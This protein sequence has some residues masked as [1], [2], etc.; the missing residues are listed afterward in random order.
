MRPMQS[1]NSIVLYCAI[2]NTQR[3]QP[4]QAAAPPY[5]FYS[6]NFWKWILQSRWL[7]LF[8]LLRANKRENGDMMVLGKRCRFT[9]FAQLATT[10]FAP[11]TN[12]CVHTK[13]INWGQRIAQIT[14]TRLWRCIPC[15]PRNAFACNGK[16]RYSTKEMVFARRTFHKKS[17]DA[18]KQTRKSDSPHKT[19]RER[20][21]Q[22]P[23]ASSQVKKQAIFF[24]KA[25]AVTAWIR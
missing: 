21:S 3:A 12:A 9:C 6:F 19:G 15:D 17:S 22:Q 11:W 13:W 14:F 25:H 16:K 8:Y 18:L 1:A 23:A 2:Y 7:L 24:A 5:I 10:P 4:A 20:Q